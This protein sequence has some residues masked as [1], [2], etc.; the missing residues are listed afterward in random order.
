LAC[1]TGDTAPFR[2]VV[3]PVK[4]S[5]QVP[6]TANGYRSISTGDRVQFDRSPSLIT[7]QMLEHYNRQLFMSK[8][9]LPARPCKRTGLSNATADQRDHNGLN[10]SVSA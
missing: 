5:C 10:L 7:S 1:I 3:C 2:A 6:E 9:I 4:R 8:L